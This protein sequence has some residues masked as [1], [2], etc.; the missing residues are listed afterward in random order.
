[1][2]KRKYWRCF[3]C[4][5]VLRTRKSAE[6]HFGSGD[7]ED[8]PPLCVEAATTDKRE[9]VLKNRELW[10]ELQKANAEI[11]NVTDRLAGFEQ[12][13]SKATGITDAT[14]HDLHLALQ[15]AQESGY[16]KGLRDA[17][18]AAA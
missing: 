15:R 8:E 12:I 3:H 18:E 4:D 16:A 2:A 5:E 17:L 10:E 7:Y 9:L 14:T 6:V 13:V 11:E 1:M